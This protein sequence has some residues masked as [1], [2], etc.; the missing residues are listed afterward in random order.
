MSTRFPRPTLPGSGK[1]LISDID[2][3][4]TSDAMRAL[5]AAFQ[6][7]P[8]ALS[9]SPAT[10][11]ERIDRL[12]EFTATF[13]TR[14][15][16]K[17]RNTADELP[18]TPDQADT[19]MAAVAALG[20]RDELPP[21]HREYDHV[22]MLGGLV[23]ACFNRPA[24]AA[25]LVDDGVVTAGA[26]TA[27]GGHRKFK[28][29]DKNVKDP[30]ERESA[31]SER[32]G[33]PELTDEYDALDLGTRLAFGLGDPEHVEGDESPDLENLPGLSWDVRHYRRGDG[34]SVRVA[35]APSEDPKRRAHTGETYAFF[36]RRM[37]S[38]KPGARLL[39]VT[40]PIYTPMQHFTAVRMLA[41]PYDVEVETI[42]GDVPD[43]AP[44]LRQRFTPTKY[45][46][47]LRTTVRALRALAEDALARDE[48]G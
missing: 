22:L 34:L 21:R 23:R 33:H 20:L 24:Y 47:D 19:T 42:G 27:L 35:A 8:D 30:K 48:L 25:R 13:N 40:T 11:T 41:L 38:L 16:D 18:M 29:S 37:T 44:A 28:A 14:L 31:I 9:G 5:I 1:D 2:A 7:D 6:G 45:L 39:L 26:V 32:L 10:L 17:E 36:A 46:N 4:L 15:E 3:Y 43:R 12:Y